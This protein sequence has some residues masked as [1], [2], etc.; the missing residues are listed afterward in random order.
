M[1]QAAPFLVPDATDELGTLCGTCWTSQASA[2]KAKALSAFFFVVGGSVIAGCL[3]AAAGM[4]DSMLPRGGA[5]L[6]LF[7]VLFGVAA[8]WDTLSA[9]PH[10]IA[11]Y[12]NGIVEARSAGIRYKTTWENLRHVKFQEFFAHRF[13]EMQILVELKMPDGKTVKFKSTHHGDSTQ[14]LETIRQNIEIEY[15]TWEEVLERTG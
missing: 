9:P 4:A 15:E 8:L 14:V 10:V 12:S 2:K 13:G 6:G 7:I 3:Y 5:A 1:N 11:A